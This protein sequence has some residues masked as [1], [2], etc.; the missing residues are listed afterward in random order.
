M[1]S[2]F[3]KRV[4]LRRFKELVTQDLVEQLADEVWFLKKKT[5]RIPGLDQL[6]DLA[7]IFSDR[8]YYTD[9]QIGSFIGRAVYYRDAAY[10][11]KIGDELYCAGCHWHDQ[12]FINLHLDYRNKRRPPALR[13]VEWGAE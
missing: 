12:A 10:L 3:Q 13:V 4:A 5:E 8:E 2:E 7:A 9:S 11:R 6:S 1:P